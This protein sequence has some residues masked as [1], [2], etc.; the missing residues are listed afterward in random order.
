VAVVEMVII[1]FLLMLEVLVVVPLVGVLQHEL[2]HPEH[3]D[4]V[5]REEILLT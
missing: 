5:M 3:Q 4:K 2:A 1:L